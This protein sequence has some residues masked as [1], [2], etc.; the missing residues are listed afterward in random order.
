M[1]RREIRGVSQALNPRLI[2]YKPLAYAERIIPIATRGGVA[3]AASDRPRS[4]MPPTYRNAVAA[5]SPGLRGTSYPGIMASFLLNS[6]GVQSKAQTR[7]R[8]RDAMQLL[9]EIWKPLT[10]GSPLRCQPWAE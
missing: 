8:R 10:Q 4:A 5:F 2:S 1:L 3:R 6:E 7:H 9:L